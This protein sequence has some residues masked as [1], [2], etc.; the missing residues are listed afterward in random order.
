MPSAGILLGVFLLVGVATPLLPHAAAD[1]SVPVRALV[2]ESVTLPPA[3]VLDR[4]WPR[5][6]FAYRYLY[7]GEP[8]LGHVYR[9]GGGSGEAVRRHAVGTT[10]TVWIDPDQPQRAVVETGLTGRDLALLALG[11][12]LL[13]IGLFGFVRLALT[14]SAASES[15]SLASAAPS[16]NTQRNTKIG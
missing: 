12:L 11:M 3:G 6:V 14:G 7:R 5:R 15:D 8:Y 9:K 13:S 16:L 1:Y 4:I 2:V 10:I